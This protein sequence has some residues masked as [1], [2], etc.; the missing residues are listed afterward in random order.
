MESNG[1]DIWEICG[2]SVG[3]RPLR[4]RTVGTGPRK[5]LFIGGIHG[6]EPEGAHTTAELAEAFKAEG[7]EN[8][9]TLTILE[10]ANPDG[11]AKKQRPNDHGVDLNRNFPATNF[12]PSKETGEKPLSEPESVAVANLIDRVRPDLIMVM[13]SWKDAHFINFDGPAYDLAQRFSATSGLELRSSGQIPAT[14]GSLGSYAGVDLKIAM[15]T[16]ELEKGSD[17]VADWVKIRQAVLDA[18]A[19]KTISA[20]PA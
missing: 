2:K 14:P 4:V 17:G 15:L 16:V 18:I 19:G 10:N 9:V 12:K 3:D 8:A 5:V 11:R 6:D 20:Q 7:L 1:Q 13:H